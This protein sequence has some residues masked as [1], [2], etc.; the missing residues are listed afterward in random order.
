MKFYTCVGYIVVAL[1]WPVVE[2]D[3]VHCLSPTCAVHLVLTRKQEL[4]DAGCT[5]L[6]LA[7]KNL[8]N[9]NFT[10]SKF[11]SACQMVSQNTGFLSAACRMIL[12]YPCIRNGH[13]KGGG[14]P[15]FPL[16]NIS[17]QN[18]MLII[19]QWILLFHHVTLPLPTTSPAHTK[20]VWICHLFNCC[21]SETMHLALILKTVCDI[22]VSQCTRNFRVFKMSGRGKR[23]AVA[24]L[25]SLVFC[26]ITAC[27]VIFHE[28]FDNSLMTI[29]K[30]YQISLNGYHQVSQV[31]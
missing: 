23:A 21:P 30:K 11:H 12:F 24:F 5:E 8:G 22:P 6:T 18:L 20:Q 15:P 27:D 16:K 29:T 3:A 26:A 9:G 7:R 31:R 17:A 1:G 10:H 13:C 2:I 28:E 19:F 4:R 14:C 25:G